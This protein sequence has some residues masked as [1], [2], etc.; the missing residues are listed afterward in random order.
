MTKAFLFDP[1]LCTGCQACEIACTIENQ[2]DGMSWRQ[3]TTFNEARHPEAPV[4]HLSMACNHCA[5][6][7]CAEHCPA[8]A[9]TK[10]PVS[11]RVTLDAD[12]CIGCKYCSWACPYDAPKFDETNGVMTKCT[13]CGHRQAEGLEPACVVQCPTGALGFGDLETLPGEET[14]LG[15]PTTE[16]DPSIR[17]IP[18]RGKELPANGGARVPEVNP[19]ISLCSEWPLAAFTLIAAV[20]VAAFTAAAGGTLE[21]RLPVFLTAALASMAL[22]SLHLGQKLRAWRA[23]LN[24]RRSW[25]SRE[26]VL[27]PAFV[28]LATL[29]LLSPGDLWLYGALLLG[30]ASLF[31]MDRVYDLVLRHEPYRLH[32]ADAVFTGVLLAALL[33]GHLPLALLVGVLKLGLYVAR[34]IRRRGK[35]GWTLLRVG[36]GFAM[37]LILGLVDPERWQAWA[38][39]GTAVG[40]LVDR[41]EF[42][43]ELRVPTPRGR[44]AFRPR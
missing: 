30:F 6:A 32:S 31:A 19:K 3:V 12:R 13:F 42:Y 11:G 38:I 24:F 36:S 22:S 35:T 1:N 2:L 41:C 9:Y 21:L 17:F 44:M 20:L 34:K 37:P 5:D 43:T 25:L 40:E 23:V 28:G 27:Y 7:P 15:L 4:I 14:A 39:A 33:L 8:L 10:D 29:H 16:P 26:I 18:W